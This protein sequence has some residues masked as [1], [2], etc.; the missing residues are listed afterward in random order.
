MV[1]V[2]ALPPGSRINEVHLA[3][4]LEVSRTPLRE[5]LTRLVGET[6]LE[7]RPRRGFYVRSVSVAELEQ[8]YVIRQHLDPWALTSAG[9]PSAEHIAELR[10]LNSVIARETGGALRRIELDDQWHLSLVR[11]CGNEVLLGLI[12]QMMLRTRR[13]EYAYFS[14]KPNVDTAVV[15]HKRIL[16]ALDAGDLEAAL[17]ALR[18]NMTSATE[19]L[20]AWIEGANRDD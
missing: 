13:Y 6:F 16:D 14:Q 18:Q 17:D 5:A 8:L 3:E 15:E 12:E 20:R 19:P 11:D 10:H 4:T 9:V 2:G 1:I 7:A